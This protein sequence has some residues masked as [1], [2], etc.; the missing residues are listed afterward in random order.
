LIPE[1]QFAPVTIS[2]V[3]LST[4]NMSRLVRLFLDYCFETLPGRINAAA[5]PME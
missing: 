2:A 4:R 1:W 5:K 3:S